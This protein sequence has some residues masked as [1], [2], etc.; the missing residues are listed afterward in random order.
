LGLAFKGGT[1]DVR[2][3][4]AVPIARE[5]MKRGATVVGYDPAAMNGFAKVV[6]EVHLAK[7][8]EEA[9]KGAHGC[10]LQADW[11]I[12]SRLT[13]KDFLEW[14]ARGAVAK[15][16]NILALAGDLRPETVLE[17]GAGTCSVIAGLSQLNFSQKFY[18]LETSPS[19]VEYIRSRVRFPGFAG[20]YLADSA[21]TG[22]PGDRFDL[23]ILS[24]VL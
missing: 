6:P 8:I 16:G 3:S 19:A 22:L 12:L 13:A 5:L 17:V 1:D 20:V 21:D 14:R 9:L 23:G 11:P 2:E 18:A 10:I 15:C 24:H 7:S 4:R